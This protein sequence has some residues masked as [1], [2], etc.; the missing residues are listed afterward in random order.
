MTDQKPNCSTCD[1]R[2][3][4]G[5]PI[6][7]EVNYFKIKEYVTVPTGWET[8]VSAVGCLSHPDARE[9]L[10]KDV[11]KELERKL[12]REQKNPSFTGFIDCDAA[13][14]ARCSELYETILLIKKGVKK[15]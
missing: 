1:K 14:S 2:K 9:Y 12:K 4:M 7:E 8:V 3:K 15:E 13:H 5:C 10:M 6:Q 11:L